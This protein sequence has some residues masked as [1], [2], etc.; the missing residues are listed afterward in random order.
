MTST[1][2]NALES[3]Y[4]RLEDMLRAEAEIGDDDDDGDADAVPAKLSD[5]PSS[6]DEKP[7]EDIMTVR[8]NG[9]AADR[10]LSPRVL[11]PKKVLFA[12]EASNGGALSGGDFRGN[13][14]ASPVK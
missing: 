6:G 2:S 7:K 9:G 10:V 5:I 11:S 3:L 8:E 12:D 13:L 14:C 4:S 1:T